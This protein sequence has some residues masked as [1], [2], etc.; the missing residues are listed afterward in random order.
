[1]KKIVL[2]GD[3]ILDNGAYVGVGGRK[4]AAALRGF[5]EKY[6]GQ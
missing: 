1:M 2:L 4:I 6:T 5:I 3:S